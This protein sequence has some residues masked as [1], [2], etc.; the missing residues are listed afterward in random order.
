LL[1]SEKRELMVSSQKREIPF[2]G[3]GKGI[4]ATARRL[5]RHGVRRG[6]GPSTYNENREWFPTGGERETL[7]KGPVFMATSPRE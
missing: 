7:K 2:R 4:K 1:Y 3:K 6:E 5:I